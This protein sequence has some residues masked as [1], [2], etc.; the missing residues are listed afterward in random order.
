MWWKGAGK[1]SC[2]LRAQVVGHK[3]EP[4]DE[5]GRH[6]STGRGLAG[7]TSTAPDLRVIRRPAAAAKSHAGGVVRAGAGLRGRARAVGIGVGAQYPRLTI[8]HHLESSCTICNNRDVCELPF[9]F[10]RARRACVNL[11]KLTSGEGGAFA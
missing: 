7:E 6:G 3:A 2:V 10:S 4:S 11:I 8:A 9:R 1:P 5:D